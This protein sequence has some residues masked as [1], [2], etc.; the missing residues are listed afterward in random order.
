[1][2]FCLSKIKL[3]STRGAWALCMGAGPL[4]RVCG[5]AELGLMGTITDR[6]AL[7]RDCALKRDEAKEECPETS[8]ELRSLVSLKNCFLCTWGR[9]ECLISLEAWFL[10]QNRRWRNQIPS[11]AT[12]VPPQLGLHSSC[13][14]LWWGTS[15]LLRKPWFLPLY[16]LTY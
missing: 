4:G 16:Q 12:P 10:P 7:G 5:G 13:C 15:A 11:S 14:W 9:L 1:M 6:T 8:K 3:L 2:L